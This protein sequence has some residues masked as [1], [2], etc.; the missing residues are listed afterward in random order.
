MLV[1]CAKAPSGKTGALAH[2]EAPVWKPAGAN[3]Q[4]PSGTGLSG[5]Q[6]GVVRKLSSLEELFAGRH[7]DREV[8]I[9]C[10]RKNSL[11]SAPGLKIK[12]RDELLAEP[13]PHRPGVPASCR[14]AVRVA[15]SLPCRL[16]NFRVG[17][18]VGLG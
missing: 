14:A 17:S 10:V 7:F 2:D 1:V 5:S 13:V 15:G 6:V 4:G 16:S 8:I 18:S 3:S 12:N 9:L 11:G